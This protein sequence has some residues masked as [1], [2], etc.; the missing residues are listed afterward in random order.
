MTL[1]NANSELSHKAYL[2][3]IDIVDTSESLSDL[4]TKFVD[5]IGIKVASYH[6]FAGLGSF[7]YKKLNRYHAFNIPDSILKF[8][9]DQK[10]DRRD[11]PGVHAVFSGGRA[12]WLSDLIKHPHIIKTGSADITN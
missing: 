12:I 8:Y 11:D 7:D 10:N 5:H 2:Q 1:L 3:A 4:F 6:H 9:D